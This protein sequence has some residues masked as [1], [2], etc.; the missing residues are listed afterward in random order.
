[1][2]Q[3]FF[4]FNTEC[5]YPVQTALEVRGR[6]GLDRFALEMGTSAAGQKRICND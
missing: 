6:C 5:E 4:F 2:S 1:M 3:L